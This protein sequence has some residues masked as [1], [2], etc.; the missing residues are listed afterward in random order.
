M[1]RYARFAIKAALALCVLASAAA[2]HKVG[3]NQPSE[4]GGGD[5]LA[6]AKADSSPALDQ[7]AAQVAADRADNVRAQTLAAQLEQHPDWLAHQATLCGPND[8]TMQAQYRV[9]TGPPSQA[10]RN[11]RVACLAKTIAQRD[12]AFGPHSGGV[13]NAN[14]L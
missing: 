8:E 3:A 10:L 13:H 6:A 5:P 11:F 12:L 7:A 14:S 2:C 9:L 4:A 1:T